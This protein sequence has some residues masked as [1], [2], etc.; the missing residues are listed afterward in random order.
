MPTFAENL[1]ALRAVE[2]PRGCEIVAV[3]W[4]EP[5]GTR[6]YS[7]AA[8][9]EVAGYENCPVMVEARLSRL[10]WQDFAVSADVADDALQL[11]LADLDQSLADLFDFHGEGVKVELFYFF[12]QVGGPSGWLLSS[13]TG[14]LRPPDSADYARFR[15]SAQAGFGSQFLTVPRRLPSSQCQAL[16]GAYL[17]TLDACANNDCPYNR[18]LVGGSVGNLN[19]SGQPYRSCPRQSR[20]DCI[21]RLGDDLSYL[22]TPGD[23]RPFQSASNYWAT[24]QNNQSKLKNPIRV[25]IGRKKVRNLDL[26]LYRQEINTGNPNQGFVSTLFLVGEGPLQSITNPR[27]NGVI[28]AAQ[29][30]NTRV[31]DRRQGRTAYASDVSNYSGTAHYFARWG[32]VNAAQ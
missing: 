25:I 22:G 20:Q 13:W 21:A 31:G 23:V 11:D 14:L 1:A 2:R 7:T 18:H 9:Q 28:I 29:H 26:L 16:F 5:T 27:V 24:T 6:Y 8:W 15:V 32:Q 19:A 10:A 3:Y 12:P 17:P 30:L 4:P